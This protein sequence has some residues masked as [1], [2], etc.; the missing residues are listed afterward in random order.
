M[1]S[2]DNRTIYALAFFIPVIVMIAVFAI[3]RIW[4][5]GGNTVMTGDT[6]YQYVD[7]LSYYKTIL[8]GNNDFAYS[9]SKNMGGEMAGFAAYYLYSPL[10]LLT[11]PFPRELL[12]AGIG[13]IIILAPG[14]ASLSMCHLLLNLEG[15]KEY[16]LMLSLCYGLSAYVVVYNELFQYYTNIILLPLIVLNLRKILKGEEGLNLPYILLL[17]F[18]IVNNYYSGYMICIYL[19]IYGVYY[20]VSENIPFGEVIKRTGRF[21]GMS[22]ISAALSCFT[23]IPALMSLSDEKNKLAVGLYLTFRPA[24]YFSKLYSGSFIGDFGAGMPNIYCGV[25]VTV[26]LALCLTD[27]SIER[28]RRICLLA[29]LLFFYFDFLI[30]TSNVIWHGFNQPIGFPYRQAFV[31]VFFAISEAYGF[32]RDDKPS[33]G[34]AAVLISV[35]LAYTAYIF[36]GGLENPDGISVTV[37]AFVLMIEI[38]ILCIRPQALSKILLFVCIFDLVF[39]ASYSLHHFDLTTVE[40]FL[41]PLE[42]NIQSVGYVKDKDSGLYR[43][44]KTYRRTHNDAM[45]MDYAGLT[46]FSSSEKHATIDFMGSLGFRD[47]ENWAM[48]CGSNTALADSILSVKYQL[49]QFSSNGKPYEMINSDPDKDIF[50]YENKYALPLMSA[51]CDGVYN[52]G[53]AEDPFEHQNTIADAINGRENHILLKQEVTREDISDRDV[54]FHID[55]KDKGLL[56][57]FFTADDTQDA[58]MYVNGEERGRYFTTYDWNV[59]DLNDRDENETVTVEFKSSDE[60]PVRINEAYAVI[61][62]DKAL[63]DWSAEVR[64]DE[65][66]LNKK[67]SSC[68]LGEYHTDKENILFS[69]P[70]DKGWHLYVDDKEYLLENACDRMMAAR[71]PGGDHM[72]KLRFISP[73]STPGMLVSCVSFAALILYM[74]RKKFFQKNPKNH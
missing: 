5:F 55:I 71:V 56:H 50:I 21:A 39:N 31:L 63:A 36:I 11:L 19:V 37:T 65:T 49:T 23:L 18:A 74:V 52:V 7:Y 16:A 43:M 29:M 70:Y 53:P 58:V 44:E 27:R 60:E 8:F 66:I 28:R 38:V 61:A 72:V 20:F 64:A 4:P 68:Y 48:Y 59:L 24:D 32:I 69:I 12:F 6:T 57:V 47:N 1:K 3:L 26:L 17:S 15:K 34:K 10:N 40:A 9:L 54:L 13:L 41:T 67:N 33:L 25:I 51:V 46:H 73:G 2:K 22:V 42:K 45:M 14:L 30:N 35:F 62:D